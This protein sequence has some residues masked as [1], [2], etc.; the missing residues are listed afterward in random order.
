MSWP[1]CSFGVVIAGAAAAPARGAAV[2]WANGVDDA[3]MT[4]RPKATR[5]LFMCRFYKGSRRVDGQSY[6]TT[7]SHILRRHTEMSA[8]AAPELRDNP[9]PAVDSFEKPRRIAIPIVGAH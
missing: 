6:L 9:V 4:N 8:D 3:P 2:R 7:M 5:S 1:N